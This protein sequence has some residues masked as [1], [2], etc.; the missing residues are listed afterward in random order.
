MLIGWGIGFEIDRRLPPVAFLVVDAMTYL[1]IFSLITNMAMLALMYR[2]RGRHSDRFKAGAG[3]LLVACASLVYA[4]L[5]NVHERSRYL[6]EV[7]S[8]PH[9]LKSAITFLVPLK[10]LFGFGFAAI[11]AGVFSGVI[12]RERGG[13][14][15][16]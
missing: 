11:G 1:G 2:R 3:I 12:S 13:G 4:G 16:A 8:I 7:S 5:E 9:W 10:Y 15:P 6:L 14:P